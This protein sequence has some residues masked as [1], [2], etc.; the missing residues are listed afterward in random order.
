MFLSNNRSIGPNLYH[1]Y[2]MYS[3]RCDG[4]YE[5]EGAHCSWPQ[6]TC[7]EMERIQEGY[8]CRNAYNRNLI[9]HMMN[10]SCKRSFQC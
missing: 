5:K 10:Y 9:K 2:C 3:C 7:N 1:T 8:M 4:K 6:R